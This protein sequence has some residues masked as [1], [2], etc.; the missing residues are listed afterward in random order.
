MSHTITIGPGITCARYSRK[1]MTW[2]P[3]IGLRWDCR[4]NL[5]LRCPG[6]MHNAPIKF[7]RALC[8]RL[9]R[10]V[11]VCPRGAQVRFNGETSEK[12]VSSRKTS[13]APSSRHFFYMRPDIVFPVGNRLVVSRQTP[14]L[15]FLA[16]PI[17]TVQKVPH[18]TRTISYLKQIPDQM[19]NAI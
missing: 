17:Q 19:S 10:S 7:S 13:L 5:S 8:S 15:G 11:G 18:A 3:L 9:V 16:T 6:V 2:S 12:P 14:S 1:R 4:C